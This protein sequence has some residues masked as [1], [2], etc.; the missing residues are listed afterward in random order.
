MNESSPVH[1]SSLAMCVLNIMKRAKNSIKDERD[2]TSL[3]PK[4]SLWTSSSTKI[5]RH[6]IDPGDPVGRFN[7]HF[8]TRIF[9]ISTDCVWTSRSLSLHRWAKPFFDV[10]MEVLQ[11][12]SKWVLEKEESEVFQYK[13]NAEIWWKSLYLCV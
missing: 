9:E 13:C 4:N 12:K 3:H 10:H 1:G 11:S 5:V 6:G 2:D 8:P 7:L